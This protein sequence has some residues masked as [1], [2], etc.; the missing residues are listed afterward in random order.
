MLSEF[1]AKKKIQKYFFAYLSPRAAAS[2]KKKKKLQQRRRKQLR[3][4]E[5]EVGIRFTKSYW[6]SYSLAEITVWIGCV[7]KMVKLLLLFFS[8]LFFCHVIVCFIQ[9]VY[10][11]F[12]IVSIFI[13]STYDLCW[14]D[15][16]KTPSFNIGDFFLF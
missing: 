12:L 5:Y 14:W 7:L 15:V 4:R 3:E 1:I 9:F 6:K 13:V 8:S 11:F 16:I 2:K 10:I